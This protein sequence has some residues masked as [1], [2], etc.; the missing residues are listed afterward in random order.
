MSL[1]VMDYITDYIIILICIIGLMFLLY[2]K[3]ITLQ[4]FCIRLCM[5]LHSLRRRRNPPPPPADNNNPP[6]WLFGPNRLPS[7]SERQQ[8]L[9]TYLRN[10]GMVAI[11]LHSLPPIPPVVPSSSSS[12]PRTATI[13]NIVQQFNLP[14]AFVSQPVT[15]HNSR[16]P[17]EAPANLSV[18]HPQ[19]QLQQNQRN[20]RSITEAA[21]ESVNSVTSHETVSSSSS[22][23]PNTNHSNTSSHTF[24]TTTSS[25]SD[26]SEYLPPVRPV[27]RNAPPPPSPAPRANY[28][29]RS[30]NAPQDFYSDNSE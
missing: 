29:L 22:S 4:L 7:F 8:R 14:H 12:D 24:S 18:P 3:R 10:M 19:Q 16:A 28:N 26:Y 11:P 27:R 20:L 13:R 9:Q 2:K 15:P 30:H 23:A 25:S 17:S 5:R 21:N 6:A 1:S